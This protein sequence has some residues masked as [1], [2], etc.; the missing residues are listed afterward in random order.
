VLHGGGAASADPIKPASLGQWLGGAALAAH[1]GGP[2][3]A[4]PCAQ[5]TLASYETRA[6]VSARKTETNPQRHSTCATSFGSNTRL[7]LCRGQG[8]GK[9]QEINAT[10]VDLG[11]NGIKLSSKAPLINELRASRHDRVAV[12]RIG[13]AFDGV[14]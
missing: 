1:A 2:Q 7:M 3:G 8:E 5:H 10:Q 14:G 12:S 13:S 9:A 6:M 4:D 11:R